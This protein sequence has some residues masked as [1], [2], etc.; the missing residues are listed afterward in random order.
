MSARA[1]AWCTVLALGSILIAVPGAARTKTPRLQVIEFRLYETD[2]A[3]G[4]QRDIPAGGIMRF[5]PSI[6]YGWVLEFKPINARFVLTETLQ[7]PASAKRWGSTDVRVNANRSRGVTQIN[8]DGRSG[9]AEHSWCV[10]D[11]DP[12]GAYRFTVKHQGQIV[13]DAKFGLTSF[14]PP[15]IR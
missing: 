12:E 2:G 3:D 8:V 6:C 13:G 10:A 4:T 1:T 14:A 7:L 5:G 9:Q 15:S 11:G